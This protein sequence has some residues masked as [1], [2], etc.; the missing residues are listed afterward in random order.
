MPVGTLPMSY[1]IKKLNTS[2]INVLSS[3]KLTLLLNK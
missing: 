2:K 1:F 3:Q